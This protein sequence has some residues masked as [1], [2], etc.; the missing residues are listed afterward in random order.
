MAKLFLTDINL[1][2]N[3]IT[4]VRIHNAATEPSAP[5]VGQVYFD[6][7]DLT[8][9]MWDGSSWVDLV[10]AGGFTEEEVQDIVGAM[11]SGNTETGI[12][13]TYEDGDGTLDFVISA[14]NSLPV[15]TGSLDLN[16]QKIVNLAPP[17]AGTDAANKNYVDGLSNGLSWK[18]PVRVATTPSRGNWDLAVDLEIGAIVDGVTV[19][20]G[21]RI[22]VK[23]QTAPEENGI[24]TITGATPSPARTSDAD[25][26]DDL[27]GAAVFVSEGTSNGNTAWIM[28]TNSPITV[29]TTGLVWVQFGALTGSF[30]G[31]YAVNVGDDSSTAIVITHNLGTRDVVVNVREASTPWAEV[32]CQVEMTSINTVTLTFNIAPTT[33][34]YR[35]IV[36]G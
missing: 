28:T 10:G 24:Y 9:Y 23:D 33:D 35:C 32:E 22:L 2:K 34:Q 14:L 3:Q 7:V 11:V 15:P 25:S 26:S 12:T 5:G 1:N 13:V 8:I 27:L 21:D 31:K 18:E 36:V 20:E 16:S 4:N 19:A 17:T 6:T 29:D 30:T